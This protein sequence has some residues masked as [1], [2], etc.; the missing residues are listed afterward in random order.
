MTAFLVYVSSVAGRK[1]GRCDPADEDSQDDQSVSGDAAGSIERSTTVPSDLNRADDRKMRKEASVA[2]FIFMH[3]R[4]FV[5]LLL[6]MFNRFPFR[7]IV[8]TDH[9]TSL[10]GVFFFKKKPPTPPPLCPRLRAALR[11]VGHPVKPDYS[12][13]KFSCFADLKPNIIL[14]DDQLSLFQLVLK[15]S[16]SVYTL[17]SKKQGHV[18]GRTEDGEA[19]GSDDGSSLDY[20]SSTSTLVSAFDRASGSGRQKKAAPYVVVPFEC[21]DCF[22]MC[23]VLAFL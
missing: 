11:S 22:L 6:A 5:W 10:R 13:C 7:A 15:L 19:S 4:Q 17:Q 3:V 12:K 20:S 16:C 2:D 21:L 9:Q 18:A 1:R 23:P 8:L 14:T